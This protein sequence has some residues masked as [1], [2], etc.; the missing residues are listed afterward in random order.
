MDIYI[1]RGPYSPRPRLFTVLEL[2][3]AGVL[4][5]DATVWVTTASPAPVLWALTDAGPRAIYVHRCA[6]A[7]YVR[8]T[9][10]RIRWAVTS[11]G[12]RDRPALDL[13]LADLP[14]VAPRLGQ[15]TVV[16]AHEETHGNVAAI[17]GSKRVAP[18]DAAAVTTPEGVVVVD[19]PAAMRQPVPAPVSSPTDFA[20]AEA[21]F[22]GLELLTAG[23]PAD[24]AEAIR[25]AP[26]AQRIPLTDELLAGSATVVVKRPWGWA[27]RVAETLATRADSQSP[28]R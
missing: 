10:G 17:S 25:H 8:V 13:R 12:T 27:W 26:G 19:L 22:I 5:T 3:L 28:A 1:A 7:G 18:G 9:A 21:Q 14:G 11:D 16:V 15:L 23:Q 24:R 4:P 6:D 20:R 2:W